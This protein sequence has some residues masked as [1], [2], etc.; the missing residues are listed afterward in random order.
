MRFG[1]PCG[2]AEPARLGESIVQR[3][4]NTQNKQ[5]KQHSPHNH[6]MYKHNIIPDMQIAVIGA[7]LSGLSAAF[8]LSYRFPAAQV[9]LFEKQR[10]LGGWARSQRVDLQGHGSIFLEG[11]PRT[12]R[13][14]GAAVLE[15]VRTLLPHFQQKQRQISVID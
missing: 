10:H 9:L 11:G 1:S 2:F 6:N 5:T 12:L 15:L 4:Q 14:Q 13:P 3:L 7:G 8:N